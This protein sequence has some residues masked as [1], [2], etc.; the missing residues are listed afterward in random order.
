MSGWA[1]FLL[2][3][4]LWVYLWA[5]ILGLFDGGNPARVFLRLSLRLGLV[6]ILLAS[7][8][9]EARVWIAAAGL[10]VVPLHLSSQHALRHIIRSGRW[11]ARR[12][13]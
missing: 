10:L 7:T 5:G 4:P 2:A 3:L 6:L 12:I 9:P 8:L 11:P 13:D 1:A